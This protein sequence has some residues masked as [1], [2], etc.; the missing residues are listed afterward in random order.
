MLRSRRSTAT[1][2][3]RRGR[4]LSMMT[5]C[6]RT[7]SENLIGT[8]SGRITTNSPLHCGSCFAWVH[9]DVAVHS[10]I[11]LMTSAA[12][13][14]GKTTA[15]GLAAFLMPRCLATADISNA[16][17]Y[18]S[19][20]LWEP[21]SALMNST[22]SLPMRKRP[23]CVRSSIWATPEASH[24]SLYRTRLWPQPFKTFAPKAIGMIGKKMPSSTLS[25]CIIVELRRKKRTNLATT[26]N[27]L[28]TPNW[29]IC[30]VG[31]AAGR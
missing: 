1:G 28:T 17:L 2:S 26:L 30:A 29:L 21:S 8:W 20:Q 25:R 7:S 31:C 27:T 12:I 10:P 15:L 22:T 6:C 3:P 11:L 16:G 23:N 19:I 5:D 4:N 9:D 14:S 13:Y 24:H 18:R